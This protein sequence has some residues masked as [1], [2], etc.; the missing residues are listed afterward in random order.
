MSQAVKD[1]GHCMLLCLCLQRPWQLFALAFFVMA[2]CI[3]KNQLSLSLFLLA[4]FYL[5]SRNT[6]MFIPVHFR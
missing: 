2:L 1:T 3:A 6:G 5:C 4:D